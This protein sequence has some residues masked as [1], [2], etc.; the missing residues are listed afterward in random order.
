MGKIDQNKKLKLEALL[1]SGFQLFTEKGVQNTTVS[2]IVNQAKLAKGTFYLYFKD[3]Y[4]GSVQKTADYR[5]VRYRQFK[6]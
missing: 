1:H 2:D 6:F 5:N 3:K 4:E